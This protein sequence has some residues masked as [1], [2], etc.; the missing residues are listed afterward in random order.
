MRLALAEEQRGKE[1]MGGMVPILR[2]LG[3]DLIVSCFPRHEV[4]SLP[5]PAACTHLHTHMHTLFP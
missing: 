5:S 1:T 3:A 4:P 2:E